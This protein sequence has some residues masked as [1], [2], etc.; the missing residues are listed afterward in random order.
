[1]IQ[2]PSPTSQRKAHV[3]GGQKR[4]PHTIGCYVRFAGLRRSGNHALINWLVAQYEGQI[5][6]RNNVES[7]RALPSARSDLLPA[8][9]SPKRTAVGLH[10]ACDKR[11][12]LVSFEDKPF[13]SVFQ[14]VSR[15]SYRSITGH[16]VRTHFHI[17]ILR[18]PF[19]YLA[20]RL[21]RWGKSSDGLKLPDNQEPAA[22]VRWKEYARGYLQF[23]AG[24]A[25]WQ[26]AISYNSWLTS[27]EYRKAI[28]AKLG[29]QLADDAARLQVSAIGGGSSFVGV[30]LQD[31][32]CYLNRWRHHRKHPFMEHLLRDRELVRL[33][34]KIFHTT[35]RSTN[36]QAG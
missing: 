36:V 24:M 29:I 17:L 25:P 4:H 10:E 19:N 14:G 27:L 1:M 18:D 28:C 35:V 30:E 7:Y 26:I 32:D 34:D 33:S 3:R 16:Q 21:E 20:S 31:V 5:C 6:F 2:E 23:A 22:L 8:L 11:L 15:A 12:H 9:Q 13:E